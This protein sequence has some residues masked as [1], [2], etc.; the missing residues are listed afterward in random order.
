MA[1]DTEQ[2]YYKISELSDLL[3]VES[4]V[5]RFW[6]KEF[7]QIKPMK[8]G[9][10]KRLYRR[11]DLESFQ[12]IKRLLYDERYTIAGAKKR[13][14]NFDSGQGELLF[15]DD[16][17]NAPEPV[18]LGDAEKYR[19]ARAL[20]DSLQVDLFE[21]RKMLTSGGP[22]RK[23]EGSRK[24]LSETPD[25]FS[26]SEEPAA[27]EDTAPPDSARPAEVEKPAPAKKSKT[28]AKPRKPRRKKDEPE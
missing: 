17:Q 1:H 18:E 11:K 15:A 10:R 22:A 7:P 5:L 25:L 9:P 3:G 19:A 6:E 28:P 20:L 23:N 16:G 26:E 4:S 27:G 14:F 13:L 2:F 24:P 21:I 8:V 12:E